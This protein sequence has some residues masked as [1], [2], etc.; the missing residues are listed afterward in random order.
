MGGTAIKGGALDASGRILAQ[1][2]TAT[3]VDSGVQPIVDQIAIMVKSIVDVLEIDETRIVGLGVGLPGLVD[4][5]DGRVINCANLPGWENVQVAKRI[6]E[7]TG[8]R[9]LME[10][11]ANNAALAEARLGAGNGEAS[12]VMLTLGTG[13]GGGIVLNGALWRGADGTAGELGHSIVHPG[14]RRCACGQAGCLE[15]YASA[16]ATARTVVEAIEAGAASTLAE[17]IRAGQAIGAADVVE[18]AKAGDEVARAAWDATCK[19]LAIAAINLQH[20]LNPQSVVLG[21]G[22]SAAGDFLLDNI[23]R[24]CAEIMSHRLGR[25]PDLRLAQLGNRAGFIGAALTAL[26]A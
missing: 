1:R 7:K 6:A 2:D 22:M 14:G 13:V 10:N 4:Y 17:R 26:D 9:V 12:M 23:K 19:Y 21:G 11:D 25:Q 24:Q 18:A 20:G 8:V 5:S 16:S 3:C 15:V